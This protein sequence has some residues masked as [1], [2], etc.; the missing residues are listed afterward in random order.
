MAEWSQMFTDIE[1]DEETLKKVR[2][3]IEDF[4]I[5]AY[6]SYVS[7]EDDKAYKKLKRMFPKSDLTQFEMSDIQI[8]HMEIENGV[9]KIQ[10]EGRWGSPDGFF[11]LLGEKYGLDIDYVDTCRGCDY[12]KYFKM[13]K[14]RIVE[15]LEA[16]YHSKLTVEKI[17]GGD[18]SNYLE[19]NDWYYETDDENAIAE[20]EE[21]LREYDA[22]DVKDFHRKF[23][24]ES[25][26]V[27]PSPKK[28]KKVSL[29]L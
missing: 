29:K 1:G 2:K 20:V 3:T 15:D 5:D 17:F 11:K 27:A 21:V 25:E 10:G 7:L 9:L 22:L 24:Y 19:A 14:G 4:T 18:V 13:E 8:N 6:K 26:N 28:N 16:P 23:S 12:T